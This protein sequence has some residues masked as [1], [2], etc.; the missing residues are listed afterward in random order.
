[1]NKYK[2]FKTLHFW[3]CEHLKITLDISKGYLLWQVVPVYPGAQAHVNILGL[4]HGTL[5]VP[6]FWHGFD[7]QGFDA[8]HIMYHII[9][10][11]KLIA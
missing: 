5:H 7:A 2:L 1:M 11:C 9:L 6:Q 10:T 8:A 4:Y 3:I